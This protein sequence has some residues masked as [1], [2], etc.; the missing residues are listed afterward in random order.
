MDVVLELKNGRIAADGRVVVGD[1]SFVA[2]AGKVTCLTGERGCGKTLL[3]RTLLGLW[4]L[5]KGFVTLDGEPI[6]PLSAPSLR[7]LMAY[8]PQQLPVPF[9]DALEALG[10]SRATAF[11]AS[12]EGTKEGSARSLDMTGKRCVLLDDAF[13]SLTADRAQ[14]LV[15][16]LE[17]LAGE[18]RAVVVTCQPDDVA[19][20]TPATT[21]VYQVQVSSS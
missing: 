15:D 6:T 5:E 4:P 14:A 7:R 20:F 21:L 9:A 17:T 10:S 12:A 19:R 18:G 2:P 11:D 16:R 3:V 8:V 1:L 13:C